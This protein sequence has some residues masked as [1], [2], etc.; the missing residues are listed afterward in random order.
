MLEKNGAGIIGLHDD[1]I[2]I[3]RVQQHGEHGQQEQ[4]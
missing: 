3:P 4:D 1:G 2:E